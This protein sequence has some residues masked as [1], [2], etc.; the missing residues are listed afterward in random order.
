MQ[1]V[2]GGWQKELLKKLQNDAKV[3]KNEYF[4]RIARNYDLKF[5]TESKCLNNLMCKYNEWLILRMA[6]GVTKNPQK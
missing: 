2:S 6:E 4:C 5:F 1:D 3:A